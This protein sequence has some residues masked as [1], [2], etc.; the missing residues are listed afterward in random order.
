MGRS[1]HP[2]CWN[3]DSGRSAGLPFPAD[4]VGQFGTL[5]PSVPVWDA[6][7]IC[8]CWNADSGRFCWVTVPALNLLALWAL[9]GRCPV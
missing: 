9:L 2:F 7:L 6:V 1:P 4:P 5:S 8:V 3:A